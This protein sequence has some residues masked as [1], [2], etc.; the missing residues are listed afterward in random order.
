MESLKKQKEQEKKQKMQEQNEE[1][2]RKAQRIKK[3]LKQYDENKNLKCT[4]Y[5]R[6]AARIYSS[7]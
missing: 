5:A 3:V 7:N 6:K 4:S 2:M 1:I